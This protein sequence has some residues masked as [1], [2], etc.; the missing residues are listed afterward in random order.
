MMSISIKWYVR[1][2]REISQIDDCNGITALSIRKRPVFPNT[3]KISPLLEAVAI[4]DCRVIKHTA[5]GR[6]DGGVEGVIFQKYRYHS[7]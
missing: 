6:N 5:T 7:R 1:K 2:S 3:K 4:L